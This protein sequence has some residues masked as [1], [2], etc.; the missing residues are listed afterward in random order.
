[1]SPTVVE[2]VEAAIE[3]A[4]VARSSSG[5]GK[6]LADKSDGGKGE[7]GDLDHFEG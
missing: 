3:L 5:S 1:M 6:S 4:N 7:S 2:E